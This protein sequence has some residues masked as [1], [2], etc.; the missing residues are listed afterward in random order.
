MKRL[1]ST[2]F[3]LSPTFIFAQAYQLNLQGARQVGMGSTG[4]ADPQNAASLIYNPGSVSFAKDNSLMFSIS[5]AI[6]KGTYTDAASS[7]V[8]NSNNP[9]VTPF[10]AAFML[11]DPSGRLRYGVTVYTPFGSTMEWEKN[12]TVNFDVRKISLISIVAQPTISYKLTDKLGIGAGFVYGYGHVDI[13]KDLPINDMNGNFGNAKITSAANSFGVNA[14][15]YY[16]FSKQFSAGITYRSSLN[17]KTA[18]SGKAEFTVP[19]S[20]AANFPNQ[21]IKAE[22]PL[23]S[24]WGIGFTYKPTDNLTINLDGT[25]ANWT[26]YDTITIHYQSQP[27]NGEMET[28]LIRKYKKGYSARIG[29]QYRFSP[30]FTGRAGLIVSK[31]P[32]SDQYVAADVPDANR[33]NPSIGLSYQV[34]NRFSLDAAFLYEHISRKSDN[35]IT[36]LNGTYKFNL[37]FPTIGLTYKL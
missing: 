17:M 5:P 14:G 2:L 1:L 8:S 12:A 29:A 6:S 20:V 7:K 33:V 37:Y 19:A 10:S 18:K 25:M 15:I 35:I 22:L 9:V 24:I 27:V 32:I 26:P 16:E 4:I 3:L 23:P 36:N 21:N 31:S 28:D 30:Q 13:E 11:G 34:S